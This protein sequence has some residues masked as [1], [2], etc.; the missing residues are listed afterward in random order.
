MLNDMQSQRTILN[1]IIKGD[2]PGQ[3]TETQVNGRI[4]L[5]SLVLG[6]HMVTPLFPSCSYSMAWNFSHVSSWVSEKNS[7]NWRIHSP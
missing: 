6:F 5:F 1:F 7:E 4:D 2:E 3:L